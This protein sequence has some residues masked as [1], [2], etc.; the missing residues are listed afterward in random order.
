MIDTPYTHT[1]TWWSL[2]END[3]LQRIDLF[4]EAIRF[5]LE[6]S[7]FRDAR[8]ISKLGGGQERAG[9]AGGDS[10]LQSR[11]AVGSEPQMDSN[12]RGKCVSQAETEM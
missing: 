4:V 10:T 2:G 7:D 9:G 5:R 11:F 6:E 12:L 8:S 3:G 1:H